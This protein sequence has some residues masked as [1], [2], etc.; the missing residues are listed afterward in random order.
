MNISTQDAYYLSWRLAYTLFGLTNDPATLLRTYADERRPWAERVVTSDKRWNQGSMA[1][2]TV[3]NEMR[4]QVLG[5]GIEELPG[6]LVS[7]K[8]DAVE[9]EGKDLLLGTLRTGRRL[10]NVPVTRWADGTLLDLHED[11]P[12]DGRYRVLVLAEQAFPQGR[13]KAAIEQVC[14]LTQ[15]FK[16]GLVEAV[17]L[18]PNKGANLSWDNMPVGL[19]AQAEMRLHHADGKVYDTYG[20]SS[21]DGA[22]ALVRPDGIV[23]V[24]A[25][26]DDVKLIEEVLQRVVVTSKPHTNGTNGKA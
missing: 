4:A 16:K 14:T 15:K 21:E 23:A 19:K 5:C 6:F 26:L 11:F 2:D 17:F 10:L 1:M 9:W 18:Q 24:T 7:D 25:K 3:L 12:S 20:V 8:N 22:I 13:S